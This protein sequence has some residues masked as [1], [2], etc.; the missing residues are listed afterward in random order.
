MKDLKFHLLMIEEAS[1]YRISEDREVT[2]CQELLSSFRHYVYLYG[3]I[4]WWSFTLL[5]AA[6]AFRHYIWNL[7]H[8]I[9]SAWNRI[10]YIFH[11]TNL[12]SLGMTYPHSPRS[13]KLGNYTDHT[14]ENICSID[15]LC[16]DDFLQVWDYTGL[17][18]TRYNARDINKEV[19]G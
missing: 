19:L 8:L 6:I 11:F 5:Y 15:V 4:C 1:S 7:N 16:F 17:G 18:Y 10:I 13:A 9:A 12:R 2:I 3:I 14:S